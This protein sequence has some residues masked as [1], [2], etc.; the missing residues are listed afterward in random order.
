MMQRW[1]MFGYGGVPEITILAISFEQ[2]LML[3][4]LLDTRYCGGEIVG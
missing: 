2:A 4:R 1:K 3:A